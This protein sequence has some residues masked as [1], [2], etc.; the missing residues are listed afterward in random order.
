MRKIRNKMQS[1]IKYKFKVV[2]L[3]SLIIGNCISIFAVAPYI[4]NKMVELLSQKYEIIITNIDKYRNNEEM[5]HGLI[6]VYEDMGY[7][8]EVIDSISDLGLDI[9]Q[10]NK[11]NKEDKL[12]YI[13]MKEHGMSAIA[14]RDNQYFHIKSNDSASVKYIPLL[15]NLCIL[16]ITCTT[17]FLIISF[18]LKK[19]IT[20]MEE[21]ISAT[22]EIA[23]GNFDVKVNSK[24]TTEDEIGKLVKNFNSMA[25]D[26]KNIEYIQ[27]DFMNNVSHEFKTPISAIK[28]FLV[29]LK[30]ENL[31]QEE[32]LE[33]I[34]II[35]DET[36]RLS[37]LS[38]NIL[39]CSK[40]DN[41]DKFKDNKKFSLD[42][43]IR[44][45]IILLEKQWSKKNISFNIDLKPTY[46]YGKEEYL[47][48]VWI[49]II[50]NAIKFSKENSEIEISC[51]KSVT[52]VYVEIKDYGCG[53]DENTKKYL[54]NKFYQGDNSRQDLGYGLGLSIS[55]RIV[56]LS[57][58]SI[59]V[60]SEL[61]KYTKFTV[62]L[63]YE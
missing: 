1:S 5:L 51:Y 19:I 18:V 55:K 3:L 52:G 49:N 38:S 25:N 42:E 60:D 26:L 6:N 14:K 57:G 22:N 48:Q 20:P 8:I 37:Q 32:R 21:L 40:L 41:M 47:I 4:K 61:G 54:F 58:G 34:D 46:Y 16:I 2:F 7:S 17:C 15:L 36:D 62:I 10:K 63:S 45:T 56:E 50:G 23:A 44:K 33:Y 27:T 39:E 53:M 30:N 43:Q 28:G 24:N 13:S 59:I 29:I 9:N 35:L 31:S 11:L 12:I